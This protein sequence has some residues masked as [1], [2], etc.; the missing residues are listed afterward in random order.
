MNARPNP[1][2]PQEFP[3]KVRQVIEQAL[4]GVMSGSDG[5][6]DFVECLRNV[7]RFTA[8]AVKSNIVQILFMPK[9]YPS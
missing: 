4:Q 1:T 3:H 7:Y 6:D 9:F 5:P 2:G 8:D